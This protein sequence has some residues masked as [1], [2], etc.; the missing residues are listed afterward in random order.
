M[1]FLLERVR[2]HI[3]NY[4]KLSVVDS[5]KSIMNYRGRT[6]KISERHFTESNK[7]F[8]MLFNIISSIILFTPQ[9][10]IKIIY[11]PNRSLKVLLRA[12]VIHNKVLAPL[13]QVL[14]TLILE[15]DL[16]NQP[17][18]RYYSR[19]EETSKYNEMLNNKNRSKPLV[20]FKKPSFRNKFE[21]LNLEDPIK[22]SDYRLFEMY[23][24]VDKCHYLE[25]TYEYRSE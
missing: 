20:R 14:P 1:F 19:F 13:V 22:D 10:P 6:K 25:R 11:Q 2:S 18:R 5:S 15:I 8:I 24:N 21:K 17:V 9:L 16:F 3:I 12:T 4:R 23:V 7:A